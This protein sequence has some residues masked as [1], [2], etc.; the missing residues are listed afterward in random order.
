TTDAPLRK[1]SLPGTTLP[2]QDRRYARFYPAPQAPVSLDLRARVESLLNSLRTERAKFHQNL[3]ELHRTNR[4]ILGI[5][6]SLESEFGGAP[7]DA[8]H[9]EV[10]Q[11]LKS[12]HEDVTRRLKSLSSR[13]RQI[14]DK[15]MAGM[16][17]KNI[18]FDLG[19]SQKTVETHRSRLMRK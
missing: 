19:L 3:E 2:K 14:L 6:R 8:E 12:Q 1:L 5:A 16:V 13:Q 11:R 7:R 9:Q 15:V 18:A 10:A 17:N 4:R